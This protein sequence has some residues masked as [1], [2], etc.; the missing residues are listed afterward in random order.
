MPYRLDIHGWMLKAELQTIESWAKSLQPGSLVVEVGSFYGRSTFCWASSAPD[1]IIYCFDQWGGEA[2]PKG[3]LT[4]KERIV[5]GYPL[6][7]ER[8]TLGNF[9]KNIRGLN[10]VLYQQVQSPKDIVWGNER[11]DVVFIDAAHSNPIDRSYIDFW[12]PRIKL[13][14][15]ICGHDYNVKAFPDVMDNVEY[16][17]DM[18]MSTVETFEHGNL[19]RI[20]V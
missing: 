4:M 13:G 19:W 14:G 10:N 1:C 12:L 8:N 20:K 5:Y 6:P 18:T 3:R 11:P 17:L 2:E 7:G 15:Y 9:K 16:I